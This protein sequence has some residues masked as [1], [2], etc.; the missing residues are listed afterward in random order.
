MSLWT[1]IREITAPK[2]VHLSSILFSLLCILQGVVL[3]IYPTKYLDHGC[4]VFASLLFF[5]AAT[6]MEFYL[7]FQKCLRARCN[8]LKKFRKWDIKSSLWCVWLV[9]SCGLMINI[10]I[11]F[12]G[13][14]QENQGETCWEKHSN[15]SLT[16]KNVNICRSKLNKIFFKGGEFYDS[17]QNKTF[18]WKAETKVPGLLKTDEFFG[19]NILKLALCSTPILMLLLLKSAR[20]SKREQKSTQRKKRR[21]GRSENETG[22]YTISK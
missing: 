17:G 1:R 19:P 3:C 18:T 16:F 21:Q 2:L 6:F 9:Y 7:R 4:W 20:E 22:M 10:A 15:I 14:I 8:W 11:I 12:D 5:F 13:V